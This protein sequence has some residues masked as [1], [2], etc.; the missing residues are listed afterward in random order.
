MRKLRLVEG[1]GSERVVGTGGQNACVTLA[2]TNE[3]SRIQ[4][5]ERRPECRWTGR[6]LLVSC[7]AGQV[8]VQDLAPR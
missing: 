2:T 7:A 4:E 6:R 5:K 3:K 1:T 8:H